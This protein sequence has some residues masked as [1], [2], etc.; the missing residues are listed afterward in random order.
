VTSTDTDDRIDIISSTVRI[1]PRLGFAAFDADSHY[2]ESL[3]AMTRHLPRE[4]KLRGAKWAE[5]AGRKRLMLGD[6]LFHFIPNATFD[7]VAKPGCLHDY[8]A[9]KLG[10][11]DAM[12][13]MGDLEPIRPE[14]RDR[15]AR[16]KVMDEQGVSE[17]WMF[18]TLGVTVEVSFQP[19]ID[20][21][22][23]TF[24]AFNRWLLEDWGFNYKNRIFAAPV[25]SL[26]DP[27]WA[28][29][30]VE[31]CIAQGAKLITLRNGPVY[32][33]TGTTSPAAP[34]FDPFWARVEEANLIMAPH[35]GDD[36]YDFL[37]KMWEPEGGNKMLNY[38]P[39]SKV[40]ANQRAVPDFFGALICHRLFERFPRLRVA[41]IEN[42]AAWVKPLLVR[43]YNGYAQTK[44]YYRK[45]PI[46]QFHEN[47]WVT[48]FWE[49]NISELATFL[50][51]ERIL[52]GSD[53]PHVEGV[54][55]PLDFLDSLEGF[56]AADRR[57]VMREN[58]EQLTLTANV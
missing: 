53:W 50:P 38:T 25:L 37:T 47:I 20:A 28:V 36:G 39:L 9:A 48:P 19:D 56:S 42:G 13:V 52:F 33:R 7:P 26:S 54:V 57:K 10:G 5:I 2:Y 18:P 14:Y 49:D 8:F 11:A 44:G 55:R 3:D 43:L 31:W 35:A 40:V 6:K 30:E 1:D 58:T 12:E 45:N 29:R 22:L 23:A 16:L 41:S 17:S 15:D 32:T 46:D 34:E 21:A 24:T 4:M 27:E 51:I